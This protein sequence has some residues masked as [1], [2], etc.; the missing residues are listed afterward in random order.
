MSA[1]F[2]IYGDRA[3]EARWR[4]KAKNGEVVAAGEGYPDDDGARRGI[5]D[6]LK[7][8]MDATDGSGL[9]TGYRVKRVEGEQ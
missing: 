7:A 5:D 6:F 8:V 2:E 9:Q 4:L 3:G 1:H